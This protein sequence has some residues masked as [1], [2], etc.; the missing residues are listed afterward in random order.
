VRI[1]FAVAFRFPDKANPSAVNPVDFSSSLPTSPSEYSEENVMLRTTSSMAAAHAL[2]FFPRVIQSSSLTTETTPT[3]IH[4][5]TIFEIYESSFVPMKVA[6]DEGE[7]VSEAN[8][9][10]YGAVDS[11]AAVEADSERCVPQFPRW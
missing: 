11:R 7:R 9:G 1:I 10:D 2:N 5:G 8:Q 6:C 4:I 3:Y